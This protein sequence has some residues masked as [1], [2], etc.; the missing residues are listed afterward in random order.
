MAEQTMVCSVVVP[1]YNRAPL[2]KR[3]LT[4][5]CQQDMDPRAFEVIVVDDGSQDETQTVLRDV[6]VPYRLVSFQQE[7]QGPAAARN[8]AIVAASSDL[9][10]CLDDDV[11]PAPD[12]LRRHLEAHEG[13]RPMAIMGAMILPPGKRL[14][15]WLE[16]EACSLDKQYQ[17]MISGDWHASHRQFYTANASFPRLTALEAGL[18]D[19]TF[20][21]AEDVEFAYRLEL[22]GAGFDFLPEA[23]VYH[24]PDRTYE[25]WLRVPYQYGYYDYVMTTRKGPSWTLDNAARD[26]Q[27]RQPAIRAAVRLLMGRDTLFKVS[28]KL[29]GFA[30]VLAAR[31]G[32]HGVSRAAYS[33]IFNVSYWQGVRDGFGS[34]AACLSLLKTG[35]VPHTVPAR[36]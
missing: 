15:P 18:F 1:T 35:S 10:V 19:T 32:M 28:V 21:R 27:G 29:A 33:A 6:E 14:A 9:I 8:R 13:S 3:F 2:L 12:L 34:R 36:A 30:A 20:R 11:M 23:V 26:L 16:W 7:N 24:E 31:A 25:Q 22:A 4:S 5:L 17:Q